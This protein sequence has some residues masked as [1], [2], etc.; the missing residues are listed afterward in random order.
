MEDSDSLILEWV[1]DCPDLSQTP[2][3]NFYE[4]SQVFFWGGGGLVAA[5]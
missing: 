3:S 5:I 2:T 1:S 4:F